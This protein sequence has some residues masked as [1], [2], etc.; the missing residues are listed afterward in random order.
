MVLSKD[1]PTLYTNLKI[2]FNTY[3]K[4]LKKYHPNT[5]ARSSFE[6]FKN[7]IS[8]TWDVI[9]QSLNAK[10]NK[11]LPDTFNH[12]N[13]TYDNKSDIANVFNLCFVS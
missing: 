3:F 10:K 6:K 2:N 4:I 5:Q 8:K 11:S 9:N 7:N 12:A 1:N 13:I